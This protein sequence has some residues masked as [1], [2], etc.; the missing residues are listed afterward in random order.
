MCILQHESNVSII[1]TNKVLKAFA[2]ESCKILAFGKLQFILCQHYVRR[3]CISIANICSI[4]IETLFLPLYCP[5][6]S[7]T[8]FFSSSKKLYYY[9]VDPSSRRQI[10]PKKVGQKKRHLVKQIQTFRPKF[11]KSREKCRDFS[12][13]IRNVEN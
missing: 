8:V 6:V 11:C 10:M 7:K 5:A 3:S 9:L 13:E 12:F 2:R 4:T 1:L